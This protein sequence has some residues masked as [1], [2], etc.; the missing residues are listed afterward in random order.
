MK[1]F[2]FNNKYLVF[3]ISINLFNIIN[4]ELTPGQG[5]K[6]LKQAN[7]KFVNNP[8][9]QKQ[10][11]GLVKGQNPPYVI[12]SC[13]DSRA[14]PEYIF[15]QPLG[16]MFTVRTAG[17]VIDDVVIDTIVFAVKSYDVV[18][19]VV[20]GHQNCGAV[21]GAL[22]RLRK[23]NGKIVIPPGHKRGYVD[24]VL[25]PIERAIVAS[26]VDIHAPDALEKSTIANVNYI[27]EQ[28]KRR[29]SI[30]RDA[31]KNKKITLVGSVYSLQTGKVK[32]LFC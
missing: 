16:N 18:N 7:E 32:F 19:L 3:L 6:N 2:N 1:I 23:N 30:I 4:S 11:Q 12:L 31:I 14:T 13:S 26:K 8:I 10:R 22:G 27:A 20:M 29:S 28:L 15:E 25:I 9:F 21:E 5:V 24:A 17:Q